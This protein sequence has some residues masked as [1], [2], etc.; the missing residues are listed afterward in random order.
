MSR[1]EVILYPDNSHTKTQ[2]LDKINLMFSN[3]SPEAVRN[4]LKSFAI[5]EDYLGKPIYYKDIIYYLEMNSTK[6]SLLE[7]DKTIN[8]KINEINRKYED[9]I[10][11]IDD[12]LVSRI[13]LSDNIEK[14]ILKNNITV[15]HGKAGIGKS[16]ILLSVL[17]GLE[18]SR[19]PALSI[20]L[21]KDMPEIN[22]KNLARILVCRIP[23]S[24][25]GQYIL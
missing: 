21:D 1:F 4:D 14:D 24:M 8:P 7:K 11:L 10:R 5:E 2:L 22:L 6:L 18:C 20:R 12:K 15:I 17:K 23:Y 16:G 3:N 13:E 25:S 9:S 19:I